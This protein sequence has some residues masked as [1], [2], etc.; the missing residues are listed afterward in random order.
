MIYSGRFLKTVLIFFVTILMLTGCKPARQFA[1][2]PIY[3]MGRYRTTTI[4]TSDKKSTTNVAKENKT[5]VTKLDPSASALVAEAKKWIGTPYRY[6]GHSRS[7]TDCSG[8]IMEVFRA[9]VNIELP[10]TSKEQHKNSTR[11]DAKQLEVGDLVFF[12]TSGSSGGVSHVGL[13]IGDNNMIHA[14]TS[15]GVMIS[16]LSENY[17]VKNYHS[18]G[19][20]AKFKNITVKSTPAQAAPAHQA[21]PTQQASAQAKST[22]AKTA[23]TKTTSATTR[24]AEVKAAVKAKVKK[25][26]KKQVEKKAKTKA[27]RTK[28]TPVKNAKAVPIQSN[29]PPKNAV[30]VSHTDIDKVMPIYN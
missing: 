8:F 9:A 19:R 16:G 6:G 2:D 5:T 4:K 29:T 21:K 20:V 26:A 23:S 25:E 22:S 13:Y 28:S 1:S 12:A 3:D 17:W 27:K 15:R 10:R 11:I 18:A 14:S 30:E 7:G 24:A